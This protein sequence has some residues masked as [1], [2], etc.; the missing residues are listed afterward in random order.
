MRPIGGVVMGHI[1]DTV[2]RKR[3]LE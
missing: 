3:A 2:G 1:G